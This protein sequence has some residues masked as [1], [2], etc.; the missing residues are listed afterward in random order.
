MYTAHFVAPPHLSWHAGHVV[1]A[2]R[3]RQQWTQVTL[4]ERAGTKRAPISPQTILR[5]EHTGTAS[6]RVQA[7]V[8]RAL[9]LTWA[10]ILEA[11]PMALSPAWGQIIASLRIFEMNLR[12][13]LAPP[14]P[15]PARNDRT[16]RAGGPPRS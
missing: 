12:A 11:V 3:E 10:E 16:P 1:R 6:P 14:A 2:L 8:A 5:L 9:D 15:A 4:G 7:G 13:E